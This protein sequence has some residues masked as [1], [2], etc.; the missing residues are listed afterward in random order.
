MTSLDELIEKK[1]LE[2]KKAYAEY[3]ELVKIR[4]EIENERD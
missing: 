3:V 2:Y 4:E 1:R